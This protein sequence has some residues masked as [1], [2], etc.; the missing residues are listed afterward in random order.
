MPEETPVWAVKVRYYHDTMTRKVI[1]ITP[2]PTYSI[3]PYD[4]ILLVEA[5]D[6]LGAFQKAEAFLREYY[7]S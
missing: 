1:G 4:K 2:W 3:P 5:V 7:S 6:E